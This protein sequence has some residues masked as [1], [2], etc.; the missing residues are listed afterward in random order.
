MDGGSRLG[1]CSCTLAL[2]SNALLLLS[3]QAAPFCILSSSFPFQ[4][5]DERINGGGSNS[6]I[7]DVFH[8]SGRFA[9]LV[10]LVQR[11]IPAR[12]MDLVCEWTQFSSC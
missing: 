6:H 3:L 9:F 2:Y 5:L 12:I 1:Q 10:R 8:G 4:F 7:N 11:D